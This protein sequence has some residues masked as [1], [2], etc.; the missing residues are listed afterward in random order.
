MFLLNWLRGGADDDATDEAEVRHVQVSAEP[1]PKS[2]VDLSELRH[3]HVRAQALYVFVHFHFADLFGSE[4]LAPDEVEARLSGGVDA[5]NLTRLL[6]AFVR[7]GLLTRLGDVYSLT[8]RGAELQAD[9]GEAGVNESLKLSLSPEM[10]RALPMMGEC[11]V[12]SVANPFA[13]LHKAQFP[14]I[15]CRSLRAIADA[16]SLDEGGS[17]HVAT[18][19]E[20]LVATIGDAHPSVKVHGETD[21]DLVVINDGL[22]DYADDDECVA[23]L[24]ACRA[25]LRPG[26]RLA[27]VTRLLDEAGADAD[28]LQMCVGGRERTLDEI[29]ALLLR[30]NMYAR[31]ERVAFLLRAFS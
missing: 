9:D 20:E 21:V 6:K 25:K 13:E 18:G 29:A 16:L 23:Y 8:D 28:L 12:G 22:H 15:G 3:L 24:E 5:A 2:R 30:C 14:S 1:L 31:D 19:D 17:C 7:L 26:G 10:F 27:I 11:L 4:A